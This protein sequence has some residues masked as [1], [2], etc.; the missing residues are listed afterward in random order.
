M[1]LAKYGKPLISN[2][3]PRSPLGIASVI[4]NSP[5]DTCDV[6]LVATGYMLSTALE[7]HEALLKLNIRASILNVHTIKPFDNKTLARE[8]AKSKIVVTLEEHSVIGGLGST[9]METLVDHIKR[10]D[11]PKILRIGLE[12]KFVHNYGTQRDLFLKFG[13]DAEGV[14]KKIQ[15]ALLGII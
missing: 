9:C 13:L 14:L 6:L 3:Y 5:N 8:A 15:N 4:K 11:L 1:R 10:C 2:S 12:D 7:V